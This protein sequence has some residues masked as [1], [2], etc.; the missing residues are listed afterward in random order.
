MNTII[1][2]F[3]VSIVLLILVIWKC[4]WRTQLFFNSRALSVYTPPSLQNESPSEV[5]SFGFERMKTSKVVICSLLRDVEPKMDLIQKRC[6]R[7]GSMFKDY[8]IVI[9]END[10]SDNTRQ[11][12]FEWRNKNPR[13]N[14][15]GC[16][17]NN[18]V[19]RCTLPHAKTK[20][21]SHLV[22]KKR[23]EKMSYLRNL[24]LDYIRENFGDFD[25][26][27]IWDM[28]VI[29]TIYLDGIADSVGQMTFPQS[30]YLHANAMCAYGIYKWGL[31]KLYYDTYA[32]QDF[33]DN[34]HINL[35]TVH[36]V[37]KGLGIPF[38][39]LGSPQPVKS[40]FG[41]FT[42]YRTKVLINQETNYDPPSE[43]NI[44]CE[45]VTLHRKIPFV[46]MNPR[47]TH[48]ILLNN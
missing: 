19:G 33:G 15:L 28:D 16:G 29:G 21:E 12:L 47:M 1:I 36:D 3:W 45:H 9:V 43:E 38:R 22:T 26:T 46:Y 42:L 48:F 35:K 32:H 6:E 5:T 2:L 7:V 14:I 25:F 17:E 24:Y 13:V 11:K 18:N 39:D 10:S 37:K 41:G 20:T 31:L 8:R 23:I 27:I 44:D 30:E 4:Y 34:F 40:C